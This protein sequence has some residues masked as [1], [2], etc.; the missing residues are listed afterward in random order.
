MLGLLITVVAVY[1]VAAFLDAKF[2]MYIIGGILPAVGYLRIPFK[3]NASLAGWGACWL[4]RAYLFNV[5]Y[6]HTAETDDDV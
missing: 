2:R 6:T 3:R 5:T 1:A 4:F